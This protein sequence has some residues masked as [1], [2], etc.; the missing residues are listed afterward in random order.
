MQK[1]PE[2]M[3]QAPCPVCRCS[4]P[5]AQLAAA[6]SPT[7]HEQGYPDAAP[8]EGAP[9]MQDEPL[10]ASLVAFIDS[11]AQVHNR[12]TAEQR[13]DRDSHTKCGA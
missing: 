4:I 8:A 5:P 6:L 7:E 2:D 11:L 9:S 12:I 13:A 10:D 1:Q 3:T